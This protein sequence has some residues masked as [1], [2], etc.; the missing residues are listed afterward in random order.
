MNLPS[1]VAE[2]GL[3]MLLSGLDPMSCLPKAWS[4]SSS[5]RAPAA[6]TVDKTA[7]K[8]S[9]F[10]VPFGL[11]D[12]KAM[13]HSPRSSWVRTVFAAVL[14]FPT[15]GSASPRRSP[16]ERICR[17]CGFQSG[18][19][20]VRTRRSTERPR[21]SSLKRAIRSIAY[22]FILP[23]RV[24][25]EFSTGSGSL[26]RHRG[27]IPRLATSTANKPL[28]SHSGGGFCFLA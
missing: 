3:F 7:A 2:L 21:T 16:L 1:S 15:T 27:F 6:K 17:R 12:A 10:M 23:M 22:N 26:E 9:F 18:N 19:A 28:P 4:R 24:S 13:P 25:K 5:A 8:I 11:V 20:Y 14:S